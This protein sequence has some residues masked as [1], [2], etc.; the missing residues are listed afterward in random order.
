MRVVIPTAVKRA[1]AFFSARVGRRDLVFPQLL[2]SACFT[3]RSLAPIRTLKRARPHD[4]ARDDA[5]LVA[6]NFSRPS[7]YSPLNT[8]SGSTRVARKAGTAQANRPNR[9]RS[10]ATPTKV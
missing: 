9:A 1:C 3:T 10:N 6:V 8:T 2:D 5:L 4:G 7:D